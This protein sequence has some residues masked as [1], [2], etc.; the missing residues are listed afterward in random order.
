MKKWSEI[1]SEF[2]MKHNFLNKK[3]SL[4]RDELINEVNEIQDADQLT[5]NAILLNSASILPV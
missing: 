4:Q 1:I 5:N 2:E 3:L